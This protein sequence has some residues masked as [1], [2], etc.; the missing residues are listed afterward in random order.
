MDWFNV[1]KK[2]L[3]ALLERKGKEFV[4][5]ELI[6]NAWDEKS[7][8][9]DVTLERFAGTRSVRLVVTDDNPE[10]FTDLSHAFTLFAHSA[11]KGD[12]EKR[13]RFNLGEKLVLALCEEAEI[14]STRGTVRFDAS[15]RHALRRKTNAGSVF[16]GLLRMTGDEV[17]RCGEVVRSLLT[18]P[19][20]VTTYNGDV[21][22]PRVP[23]HS[24]TA[25]LPTEISDAEGNLRPS[26]R[27]TSVAIH[28]PAPGE[29][30]MLYELG[31]PVVP[32]G[33]RWHIDVQQKVPLNFDRDNVPAS[34][35]SR[36]RAIAVEAMT[37]SLTTEDA[38][39]VWVRDAVQ[40]HGDTMSVEAVSRLATL[41]FGEKAVAYDP[42]DPE[43]NGLAVSMGYAVVHGGQMSGAEWSAVRR[44]GALLPAGRVTPSPKPFSEDGEPQTLLDESKWTPAMH[45]VVG[46]AHRL[47]RELLG[48]EIRVRMVSDITWWPAAT[49]GP[50]V[51]TFNLGKLGHRFFEGPLVRINQL[52]VHEFGHHRSGDH[53][54]SEYHDALCELGAKLA[55]LALS[56]PEVFALDRS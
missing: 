14:S 28:D 6:Q 50:G 2:G 21:L 31:I 29:V 4:L 34:F 26:Q 46:Y 39:S 40:R 13:G 1:D 53:L 24:V 17:T 51:L 9:V 15:G 49:Y 23:L 48:A 16:T 38:N 5:L 37:A 20:I 11:K 27:K 35:L 3:A 7:S 33:D 52:L 54:S 43:A 25:T 42:S 45:A 32:T 19:H 22:S 44:A 41:R 8:R 30:A 12:A 55:H 18:P 56:R 36:V 10:G 47:A